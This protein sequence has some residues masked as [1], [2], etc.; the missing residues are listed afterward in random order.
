MDR[1]ISHPIDMLLYRDEYGSPEMR[2]IFSEENIIQKWLFMDA[3]VAE[4]ESE[5]GIIPPQ[6]AA[7]IRKKATIEY[8]KVS[9]VAELTR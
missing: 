4:V 7:E 9:R 8:V 6:A 3:A 5:L 2:A 1:T